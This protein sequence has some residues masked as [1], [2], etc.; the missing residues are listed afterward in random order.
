[1]PLKDKKYL[2]DTFP[3]VWKGQGITYLGITLTP[4]TKVLFKENYL[5][6]LN[7]ISTKQTK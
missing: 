1:M 4:S 2:Q 5:P 7:T 6:F 3:Y